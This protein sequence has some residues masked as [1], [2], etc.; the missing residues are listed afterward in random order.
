[1]SL[2]SACIITLSASTTVVSE[3]AEDHS[4]THTHSPIYPCAHQ[5]LQCSID[6][7]HNG[8]VMTHVYVTGYDY[9]TELTMRTTPSSRTNQ[10]AGPNDISSKR[11]R[12]E[13]V[14]TNN[15]LP[16]GYAYHPG[17]M[18]IPQETHRT[19]EPLRQGRAASWSLVA[20]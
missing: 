4:P 17:D 1:M 12:Y 18:H 11:R 16:G 10:S 15:G 3:L 9:T 2:N 6:D 5:V 20:V 7:L 14:S 8:Y 19:N 13:H